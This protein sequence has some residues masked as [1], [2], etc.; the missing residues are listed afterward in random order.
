MAAALRFLLGLVIAVVIHISGLRLS[1]HFG[2][3]IDPFLILAIYHSLRFGPGWSALG[4]TVAGL[5]Q[6][7]LSGGLYGLH[8]F[9][10]TLVA[11]VATRVRLRLVIQQPLQ[12]GMLCFLAAALQQTVLAS[13]QFSMTQGTELPSILDMGIKMVATGALGAGLYVLS[14]K[15]GDWERRRQEQRRQRPRLR[16]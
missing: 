15:A 16:N 8:G 14:G 6:D 3:W 9:A 2:Q 10:N 4:G 13:L 11:F 12:V 7:A 5:V 1:P